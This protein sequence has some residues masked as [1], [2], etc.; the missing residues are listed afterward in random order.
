MIKETAHEKMEKF[1]RGAR[2]SLQEFSN[3]Y[4]LL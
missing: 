2:I 1:L 3:N 4:C